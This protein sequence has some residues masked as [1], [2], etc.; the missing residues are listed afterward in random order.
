MYLQDGKNM[1]RVIFKNAQGKA[2][3]IFEMKDPT[4]K[5]QKELSD[6][7]AEGA[8][9]TYEIVDVSAEKALEECYAKRKAEYPSIEEIVEAMIENDN[10][11]L[12]ALKA[13]RNEIKQKYPKP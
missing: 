2:Y 5:I 7:A 8:Q 4:A 10:A 1:K 9:V 13:K 3:N 6:Q 11:K 12:N